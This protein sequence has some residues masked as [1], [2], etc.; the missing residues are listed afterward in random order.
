MPVR[1][2]S[3]VEAERVAELIGRHWGVP[4]ARLDYLPEGGGAYHWRAEGDDGA[5]WFVTLDDLDDKPWLGPSRDQVAAGLAR[6]Y[7]A[8]AELR[9]TAGLAFVVAPA[10]ASSGQP[11]VPVDDRY[12]V[13]VFPHIEGV[14][15]RWG[16][17]V[18]GAERLGLVAMLAALH[19]A[20]APPGVLRS[21][22]DIP[23]REELAD[24]AADVAARVARF[25]RLAAQVGNLGGDESGLVMTHGEPHP[26]NLI[27]TD[28]GIALVDWDTVALARPERDLWMLEDGTGGTSAEY[29]RLT[30]RPVD[31]D[32]L[33]LYRLRWQLSDMAAF[34]AR[35]RH[36][37]E[38][39]PDA[40]W[41]R[42]GLEATL[43]DVEP[44]PYG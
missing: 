1:G 9:Q 2:P 4:L 42:A 38:D 3:P 24:Y 7:S 28:A 6:A 16:E 25:E 36:A 26:G 30:G 14:A 18:D 33:A 11:L 32:A 8:A 29:A 34:T 43:A 23:G 5:R 40:A 12:T 19:D 21:D 37:A 27:R 35:L 13:S 39:D 31:R 44:R 17:A 15:G 20:P 41:A 22:L 10:L